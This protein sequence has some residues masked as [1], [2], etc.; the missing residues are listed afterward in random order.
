MTGQVRYYNPPQD[1]GGLEKWEATVWMERHEKVDRGGGSDL[2][3]LE[4]MVVFKYHVPHGSNPHE[5]GL[6]IA[7]HYYGVFSA[8]HWRILSLETV[9]VRNEAIP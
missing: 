2:L 8:G 4:Q 7:E 6:K 1:G 9:L 5:V 3:Q